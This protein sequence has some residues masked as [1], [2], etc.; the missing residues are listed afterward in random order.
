MATLETRDIRKSLSRK[1]FVEE[2]KGKDHI[3]LNYILENGQKTTI[4]T[5]IS[6]GKVTIGEP[7]ISAMARQ[8]HID[9]KQFIDLVSCSLSK[10]RYY[11]FV[12]NVL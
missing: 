7:L 10:E 6:H 5:K 4:R 8:L 2:S 11:D 9:K 12:K 3:W 1:G